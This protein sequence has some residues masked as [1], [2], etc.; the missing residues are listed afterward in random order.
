MLAPQYAW[1][2]PPEPAA[3]VEGQVD[4]GGARLW[5][6]DTGGSGE[7]VVFSHPNSGSAL[8]WKYQQPVLSQA[9]YR[10]IAYS[11]RGHYG[12]DAGDADNPG[13]GVDD[14]LRLLDHLAIGRIHLVGIAGG[15]D[16][17]P[18]FAVSD[19][20]RLFSLVIGC[21]IGK[22]GD[23]AYSASDDTLLPDEFRALPV[24]LRELGPVYRAA[25]PQGT[26]E[27]RALADKSRAQPVPIRPKSEVTPESIAGI[28]ASTLLFTGDSDLYMPPSRLRA[29]A[30]Y[31]RN[32]ELAIFREAGHA[33]YWEQPEAFNRMLLDFLGRHAATGSGTGLK[34]HWSPR[35]PYVR[36]VMILAHETGLAGSIRLVRSVAARTRIN[37][38]IME[39][40]PVGRIPVL[41]LADGASLTGSFAICDYLDSR[42]GK[43]KIIPPDGPARWRELELHGIADGLLDLLL[44]WRG[45]LMKP[46][47]DRNAPLCESCA[48]R[49]SHCLSWLERRAGKFASEDYAI[50]QI[51]TGIA[52]DYLD[53]RFAGIDWRGA[54]PVLREW[55]KVFCARASSKATEI[56]DDE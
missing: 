36:K 50:G 7:P 48:V 17:V 1:S 4:V 12:S 40:S 45:E 52:L 18:D 51:T 14:L 44:V 33:P 21:T 11:R 53:F 13:T 9:G 19:P 3:A 43:R 54:S 55:H 2:A 46:E 6:Q 5:Y 39:D 29:Y 8:F 41:T 28:E 25:N 38:D 10:V 16:I 31:W 37:P 32:P 22:P 34:L 27:W 24:W 35:S 15:A 30:S 56:V 23:P 26:A 47:E 42:H 20:D 49:V